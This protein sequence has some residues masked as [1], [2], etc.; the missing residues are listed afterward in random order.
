MTLLCKNFDVIIWIILNKAIFS[1]SYNKTYA[2]NLIKT[3][4][5]HCV[6]GNRNVSFVVVQLAG[7]FFFI[8][9]DS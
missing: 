6:A 2:Q 3:N 7:L 9:M 4:K 5:R 1:R 8:P